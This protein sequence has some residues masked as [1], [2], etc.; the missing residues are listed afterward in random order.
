MTPQYTP[1]Y[2]SISPPLYTPVYTPQYTPGY[3]SI[4]QYRVMVLYYLHHA[5]SRRTPAD[6]RASDKKSVEKN[7]K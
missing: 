1:V 4:P 5:Q 3:P 6:L 7:G 2:P